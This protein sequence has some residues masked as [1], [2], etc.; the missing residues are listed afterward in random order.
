MQ[1]AN[2]ED[3]GPMYMQSCNDSVFAC[4][5]IV[6]SQATPSPDLA[7]ADRVEELERVA[8]LEDFDKGKAVCRTVDMRGV[9]D[10]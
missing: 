4:C 7:V 5:S 2:M 9:E 3:S 8:R 6:G 10:G 1:D